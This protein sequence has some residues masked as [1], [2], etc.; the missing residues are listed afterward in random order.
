MKQIY[1]LNL[2]GL[3]ISKSFWHFVNFPPTIT[4]MRY[5]QH[6]KIYKSTNS[7]DVNQQIYLDIAGNPFKLI[8]VVNMDCI[9]K[10]Y[11]DIYEFAMYQLLKR[12]FFNVRQSY[13]KYLSTSIWYVGSTYIRPKILFYFKLFSFPVVGFTVWIKTSRR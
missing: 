10:T 3:P 1:P 2:S 12:I 6:K 5:C 4:L 11:S 13:P 8:C 7:S 9:L